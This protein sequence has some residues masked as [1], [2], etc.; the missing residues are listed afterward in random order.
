[1]WVGVTVAYWRRFFAGPADDYFFGRHTRAASGEMR[2]LTD[3][4]RALL[5]EP[6]SV[7]SLWALWEAV[8]TYTAEHTWSA[9]TSKCARHCEAGNMGGRGDVNGAIALNCVHGRISQ[10]WTES[11]TDSSWPSAACHGRQH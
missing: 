7:P 8:D 3:D 2:A 9:T 6:S 1:M 4:L 10:D 11:A 5:P